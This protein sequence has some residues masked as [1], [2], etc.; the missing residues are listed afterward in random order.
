M[1]YKLV[2][3]A[4]LKQHE[5]RSHS[6]D[7]DTSNSSASLP[8]DLTK[9]V[10][11]VIRQYDQSSNIPTTSCNTVQWNLKSILPK[12]CTLSRSLTAFNLSRVNCCTVAKCLYV[13]SIT[14]T[15]RE[16]V[17]KL[18]QINPDY[19]SLERFRNRKSRQTARKDEQVRLRERSRDR[20]ARRAAR[21][22]EQVRLRERSRDRTAR[23]A[24]RKDE[25]VRL[26]ER[27]RDRTAR[28]AARKDE[29][30]RLQERS[31]DRSARQAARKDEQLDL[32]IDLYNHI[33]LWL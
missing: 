24:A 30:V 3:W 21:K 20:A 12:F 1:L 7:A 9:I 23:R 18:R 2:D 10:H 5:L 19:R 28:R 13:S 25:Q 31:R 26:R 6:H 29:Q 14:V 11:T 4:K 15:V 27:S 33:D 8:T 16:R 22:D 17:A 32:Y